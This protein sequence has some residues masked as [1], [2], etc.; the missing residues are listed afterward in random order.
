MAAV[1]P[2][3][4]EESISDSAHRRAVERAIEAMSTHLDERLSLEFLAAHAFFS[5]YHFHS[6]FRTV[7]GVPPGRFLTAWRLEAEKRLL[8]T[9]DLSVTEICLTVGYQSLGTFISQFS[10]LVGASPRRLREISRQGHDLDVLLDADDSDPSSAPSIEG[11]LTLEE[12]DE[13]GGM[14][15]IGL[16]PTPL[17]QGRPAGCTLAAVPGSYEVAAERAGSF[18]VLAFA[19]PSTGGLDALLDDGKARVAMSSQPVSITLRRAPHT[20]DLRLRPRRVT[21]PPIPLAPALLLAAR[22][23]RPFGRYGSGQAVG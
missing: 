18:Y 3:L 23:V 8:L 13:F 14:A 11:T 5:P 16:F 21:D 12:D 7:M 10:R 9:S 17:A 22:R 1:S 15:A 6:M 19:M 20:L 4:L 2:A